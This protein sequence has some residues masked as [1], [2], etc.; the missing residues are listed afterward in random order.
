[1]TTATTT[2]NAPLH[3]LRINPAAPSEARAIELKKET[4]LYGQDSSTGKAYAKRNK[5]NRFTTNLSVD[6]ATSEALIVVQ[7]MEELLLNGRQPTRTT[8]IRR[9]LRLYT[10]QLIQAKKAGLTQIL[11]ME[12]SELLR[13]VSNRQPAPVMEAAPCL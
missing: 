11:D 6:P 2:Q 12:R 4:A 9:A 7:Y 10:R 1:M 8:I 13:M 3:S 5:E